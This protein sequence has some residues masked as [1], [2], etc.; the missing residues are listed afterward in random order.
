MICAAGTAWRDRGSPTGCQGQSEPVEAERPPWKKLRDASPSVAHG[1][2][3]LTSYTTTSAAWQKVAFDHRPPFSFSPVFVRFSLC[4]HLIF[5]PFLSL[6][7]SSASSSSFSSSPSQPSPSLLRVPFPSIPPFCKASLARS[8]EPAPR[9]LT[10]GR[11]HP[12][13]WW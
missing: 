3:A 4:V 7:V 12:S 1:A 2:P 10:T 5:H 8:H 9:P 13:L 6:V 11:F